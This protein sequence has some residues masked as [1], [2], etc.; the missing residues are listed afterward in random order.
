MSGI[1]GVSPNMKSGVVGSFNGILK[2]YEHKSNGWISTSSSSLVFPTGGMYIIVDPPASTSSKFLITYSHSSH[3]NA[4]NGN[5]GGAS[6]IARMPTG[7]TTVVIDGSMYYDHTGYIF[8]CHNVRTLNYQIIDAPATTAV[9]RYEIRIREHSGNSAVS[10]FH[11]KQ[12]DEGGVEDDNWARMQVFELGDAHT[13]STP[14][15]E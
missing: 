6:A 8:N 1:I 14:Y 3:C 15:T 2:S 7:G 12:M 13:A 9:I 10:W 11:H 5:A 4:Q